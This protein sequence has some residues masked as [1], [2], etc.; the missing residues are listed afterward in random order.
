MAVDRLGVTGE[1]LDGRGDIK[2]ASRP[3]G[4]KAADVRG[5]QGR[6]QLRSLG[7]GLVRSAPPVVAGKILNGGKVPH[8]AGGSQRVPGSGTAGF[9]SRWIPRSAH[10]DRLREERR[11]PGMPEAVHRV[12][13]EDQR[14]MQ[15]GV[16]DRVLLDHGVLV[17]PG[18]TGGTRALAGPIP[19]GVRA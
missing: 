5:A 14:D 18:L 1:V 16:L 9:S 17:G 7:P 8:P 6:G 10:A 4:L 11:L 12:D 19:R 15:A 13:S 3:R 2:R